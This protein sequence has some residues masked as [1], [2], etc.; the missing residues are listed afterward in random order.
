MSAM[1]ET[2]GMAPASDSGT[3][4][5][6]HTGLDPAAAIAAW[7]DFTSL[8]EDAAEVLRWEG[9]EL[10]ELDRAEG[11]RYLAQLVSVAIDGQLGDSSPTHPGF[12]VLSNGFG[13]DNPDNRYIGS[14]VSS[15]YTYRIRGTAGTLS[16]LS[17]AA[18]NQN[19]SDTGAIT[20]G[21]GHLHQRELEVAADGTFEV[22]ASLEP[23][24]GNWLSMASDTSLLLARQTRADPASE[25]WV[26]LDIECLELDEPPPPLDPSSVA[27]RLAMV[28]LYV[29]GA[30]RWF[31][32]WVTPWIGNPNHFARADPTEQRRMGG[33][34]NILA[35]S[36][37]WSL[38][39]AES[40]EVTFEPP[41]CAYWNIQ[42]AN[43]WAQSLDV[44]RQVWLNGFSADLEADGTA[45]FLIAAEDPG[46]GNWLDTC[47]HRHGL[48]HIRFVDSDGW[49][50][51]STH[52]IGG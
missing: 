52:L 4:T 46:T 14:P 19:F 9:L 36:G 25:Q 21:A 13:M 51:A 20:G 38:G 47:E 1:Y 3:E 24:P 10:D 29:H 37:Y 16:Y 18:Q 42:L 11:L 34:P 49:P 17:F 6:N 27:E 31:V 44:R 39:E 8:L 45:R 40:L 35:Q 48:M 26:E 43:V 5:G 33:D 2:R 30:S 7:G 32:D 12:H 23:Q 15:R 41:E 22:T 28:A 50:L